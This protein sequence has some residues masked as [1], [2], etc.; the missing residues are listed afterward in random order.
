MNEAGPSASKIG[1]HNIMP[2]KLEKELNE[3]LD[4]A[5]QYMEEVTG[6]AASQEELARALK[7][8]FVLNEIKAYIEMERNG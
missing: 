7:K 2:E 5:M 6:K 4:Y 8:Y 3:A 1:R